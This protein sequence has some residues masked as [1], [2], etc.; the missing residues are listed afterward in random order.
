MVSLS[1]NAV[2]DSELFADLM[3]YTCGDDNATD[4]CSSFNGQGVLFG[5]CCGNG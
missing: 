1:V 3:L 4:E 5:S 2:T